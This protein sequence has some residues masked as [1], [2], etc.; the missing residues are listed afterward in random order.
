[1]FLLS[2][3]LSRLRS[4]RKCVCEKMDARLLLDG[5]R[6]K[7]TDPDVLCFEGEMRWCECEVESIMSECISQVRGHQLNESVSE[8]ESGRENGV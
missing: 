4:F 3:M 1:M 5:W 7:K 6:E 8:S 2:W